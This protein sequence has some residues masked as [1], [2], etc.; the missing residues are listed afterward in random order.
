[1]NA[2]KINYYL[3]AAIGQADW[4]GIDREDAISLI[5]VAKMTDTFKVEQM[6]ENQIFSCEDFQVLL[7]AYVYLAK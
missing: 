6:G 3:K 4:V 2:T 7:D 1:M 5:Q